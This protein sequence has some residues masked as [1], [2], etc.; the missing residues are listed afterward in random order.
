VFA[1]RGKLTADWGYSERFALPQ[2]G[3]REDRICEMMAAFLYRCPNTGLNVQ[4]WVADDPIERGD[5][6]YE[7]LTCTACTRVHLVNPKTGK[8]LGTGED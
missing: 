5:E 7:S 3:S 8:V 4:G 6:S 1:R 2:C